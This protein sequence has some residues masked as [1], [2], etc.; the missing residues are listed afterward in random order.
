[1]F[2]TSDLSLLQTIA[3]PWVE[4]GGYLISIYPDG[5]RAIL[6]GGELRVVDAARFT[7]VEELLFRSEDVVFYHAVF[8]PDRKRVYIPRTRPNAL[9]VFDLLPQSHDPPTT[10][11][12]TAFWPGDGTAE[13]A[14][15]GATPELKNG[16]SFGPGRIGRAFRLDGVDDFIRIARDESAITTMEGTFAAWVKVDRVGREMTVADRQFGQNIGWRMVVNR[17]AH[18]EFCLAGGTGCL[19]ST[20]SL[21]AGRWYHLAGVRSGTRLALYV[22]GIREADRALTTPVPVD[23][24]G[25]IELHLGASHSPGAFLE[26]SIDEALLYRRALEP[27]E[28]RQLA[29]AS[30]GT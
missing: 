21:V 16:A 26:G 28:I 6:S 7:T 12:L 13:D 29:Q 15:D 27:A 10:A 5:S 9:S 4:A 24:A 17:A 2:R 14:H 22:N 18:L 25:K 11:G 8:S 30:A 3:F 19:I 20:T 23:W 1:V